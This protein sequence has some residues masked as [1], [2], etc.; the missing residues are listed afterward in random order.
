MKRDL[1]TSTLAIICVLCTAAVS[2]AYGASSV[3]SLGGAGTYTSASSAAAAGSGS[4]SSTASVRGG[5]VR[6]NPTSGVSGTSTTIEAGTT[7]SGRVATTPRLSIGHYLGGGT[8]VSGGS[9]LRPQ[10][11]GSSGG[12]SSTGGGGS[13]DP[14]IASELRQEVDQ[15]HR[16]MEDLRDADDTITDA[17]LDKQDKIYPGEDGYIVIDDMTNE[18]FVDVDA[19]EGALDLVAGQDGREVE[20]GSNDTDLLWRYSGDGDNDWRVLISKSEITGPQGEKGEPGEAADLEAYSTTE[21]MNLAISNAITNLANTYVSQTDFQKLERE[22]AAKANTVDVNAQLDTKANVADVYTKSQ[23]YNKT[24]IDGMIDQGVSGDVSAALDAKADK[25]YVDNQLATKADKSEL[26]NYATVG[27][28]TALDTEL[29]EINDLVTDT[30]LGV[31][32]VTSALGN[33]ADKSALDSKLD[34]STAASTYEV[35]TNKADAINAGNQ[36]STDAY[37]SIKAVVEWTGEQISGLGETGIPVN[38]DNITPGSITGDKLEDGTITGDKIADDTITTDNIADGTISSGDL[39]TA[40][41]AEIDGKEDKSNKIQEITAESTSDQ[42]PSAVAVRT[43]LSS[44]ADASALDAIEESVTNVT[45]QYETINKTVTE[46]GDTIN[47]QDTGLAAQVK[48]AVDAASAAQT[49]AEEAKNTATGAQG[50]VDALEGVVGNE[51]SGLVKDVNDLGTTVGTLETTV[52]G[53]DT[54]LDS[55]LDAGTAANTYEVLA[56]K[57]GTITADNQSSSDEYPTVGAIT[58]WTNTKIN[59]LADSGIPVNPDSIGEGAIDTI[60]IAN[61]AVTAD[62]LSNELKAEIDGKADEADLG[63]LAKKDQIKNDDVADDAAIAKSKLASDVQAA[64]DKAAD[65]V[66]MA[67]ASE[68]SVLGTDGEGN[69]VWYEIAM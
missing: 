46:L 4:T 15:L 59:E 11:P 41:N 65:A 18:I 44:K 61:G 12:G 51:E 64:L 14:D 24:E 48:D 9:S 63:A 32:N 55:K 20:L 43:A 36:T 39:D 50:A 5:S 27:S 30:A 16:D 42:Y 23:V 8:S 58:Q 57:V 33:K 13:M 1:K 28:V 22:V 3:R 60:N 6:V 37:P 66:S 56:N 21:E 35:L 19:L 25:T 53:L 31:A 47:N 68:N 38:P 45:N 40:L 49:A 10:T 54:E 17:L 62:K 67:G 29:D 69:P 2:G 52:S 7:T 26:S 34:A